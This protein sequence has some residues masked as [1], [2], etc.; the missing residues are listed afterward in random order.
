MT[1]EALLGIEDSQAWAPQGTAGWR[2]GTPTRGPDGGLAWSPE[3]ETAGE[4]SPGPVGSQAW[5]PSG[6]SRLEK[7]SANPRAGR[8]PRA[9]PGLSE[10][11]HAGEALLDPVQ[12]AL[13]HGRLE[14]K[15]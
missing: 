10:H 13:A 3:P 7:G 9:Q 1:G 14:D 11:I 5:A 12:G 15:A 8:G 4:A 2:K 6:Y